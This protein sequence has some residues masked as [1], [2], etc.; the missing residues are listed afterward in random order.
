MGKSGTSVPCAARRWTWGNVVQWY[1]L[2]AC[3]AY[4]YKHGYSTEEKAVE[5]IRATKP[6][7]TEEQIKAGYFTYVA[8]KA[9]T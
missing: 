3:I 5:K 2:I 6:Q 9:A 8:F 1:E 4:W 7:F